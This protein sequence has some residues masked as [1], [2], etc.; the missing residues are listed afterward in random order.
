MNRKIC[1][2]IVGKNFRLRKLGLAVLITLL[3]NQSWAN[4]YQPDDPEQI[5]QDKK[6]M[7]VAVIQYPQ[8]SNA[9]TTLEHLAEERSD[10]QSCRRL[11][12]LIS[13]SKQHLNLR[14]QGGL[15]VKDFQELI[16]KPPYSK[17]PQVL[18]FLRR[19]ERVFVYE[20]FHHDVSS[21]SLGVLHCDTSLRVRMHTSEKI[22]LNVNSFA[23]RKMMIE[24]ITSHI[25]FPLE[26]MTD[27]FSFGQIQRFFAESYDVY[28]QTKFR[29]DIDRLM[30]KTIA[31]HERELRRGLPTYTPEG[32]EELRRRIREYQKMLSK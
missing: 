23:L 12:A 21:A 16:D 4:F 31:A 15:D 30:L 18:D 7:E 17:H 19:S 11:F 27:G 20:R 10:Q 6:N 32:Q 22:A 29:A 8:R 5:A 13:K 3:S 24:R 9:R 26:G 28:G 1:A 2:L 25:D 14:E